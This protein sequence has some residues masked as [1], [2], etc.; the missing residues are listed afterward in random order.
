MMYR[1]DMMYLSIAEIDR[2]YRVHV[3]RFKYQRDLE[4]PA[5]KETSFVL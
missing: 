3:L 4:V 2:N 1:S 5:A